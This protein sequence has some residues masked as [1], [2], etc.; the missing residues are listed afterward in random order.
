MTNLLL[1]VY[2]KLACSSYFIEHT[3]FIGIDEV[4]GP[5][6]ISLRRDKM[7]EDL[8]PTVG[9]PT[10]KHFYRI[11]I[12]TCQVYMAKWCC[13]PIVATILTLRPS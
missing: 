13:C 10:S 3:N 2:P 9:G 5:V 8:P 12:R 1:C 4:Y 7:E 11:I 6:A